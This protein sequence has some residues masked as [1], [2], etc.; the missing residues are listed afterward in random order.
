MANATDVLAISVH[1]TNPQN[2]IEKIMRTRIY[3]NEN[4]KKE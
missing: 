2:L 3:A 4:W 1:G